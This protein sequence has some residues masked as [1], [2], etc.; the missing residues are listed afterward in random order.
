MREIYE[1]ERAHMSQFHSRIERISSSVTEAFGVVRK[2]R[3]NARLFTER[4][5]NKKYKNEQNC[6]TEPTRN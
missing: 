1:P 2:C 5:R 3:E 6:H 4:R